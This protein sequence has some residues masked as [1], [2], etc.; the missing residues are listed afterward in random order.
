[1]GV[2]V[3]TLRE[4]FYKYGINQVL[5]LKRVLFVQSNENWPKIKVTQWPT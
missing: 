2:E 1:M 3:S 4:M 5:R